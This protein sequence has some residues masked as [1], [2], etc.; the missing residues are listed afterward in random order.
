MF[1]PELAILLLDLDESVH[2]WLRAEGVE[3]CSDIHFGWSSEDDFSGSF[4]EFVAD[5]QLEFDISQLDRLWRAAGRAARTESA[6]AASAVSAAR[7]SVHLPVT[8]KGNAACSAA[9]P[10]RRKVMVPSR[11]APTAV[12]PAVSSSS[13]TL[14]PT[15]LDEKA[16]K[17]AALFR[18]CAFC[19]KAGNVGFHY[20]PLDA[21]G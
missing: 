10:K 7:F 9:Q 8:A 4:L 21:L 16:Q 17:V 2:C 1:D 6:S 14:G 5:R 19:S 11:S 18:I 3:H 13:S 15:R 12:A 20:A